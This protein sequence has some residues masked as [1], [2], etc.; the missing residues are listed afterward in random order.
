LEIEWNGLSTLTDCATIRMRTGF[1]KASAIPR[2]YLFVYAF[3]ANVASFVLPISDLANLVISRTDM[4]PLLQW[5]APFA[6][7]RSLRLLQ[8]IPSSASCNAAD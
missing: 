2:P 1:P 4:P 5:T 8:T 7:P 6:L 3:I